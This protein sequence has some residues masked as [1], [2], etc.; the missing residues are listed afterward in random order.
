MIHASNTVRPVDVCIPSILIPRSCLDCALCCQA[1]AAKAEGFDAG[2][3]SLVLDRA[4]LAAA[5]RQARGAAAAAAFS[6]STSTAQLA[7]AGACNDKQQQPSACPA[8]AVAYPTSTSTAQR[9]AGPAAPVAAAA[10]TGTP[11]QLHILPE[12]ME[13]ALDGFT[14]PAFWGVSQSK[15]GGAGGQ[16]EGWGDVGAL[17]EAVDALK[18]SLL[19]PLKYPE[20]VAS[21]PLRMRT[22]VLLYGKPCSLVNPSFVVWWVHA[23][24]G[25]K[26]VKRKQR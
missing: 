7:G 3:L 22:G 25:N 4:L 13:A 10:V 15:A 5:R 19:L 16:L 24:L 21:A 9:F 8:G 26:K 12:D 6:T 17:E 18:E 2:D 23:R 20:L 11:L 1:I 14:P